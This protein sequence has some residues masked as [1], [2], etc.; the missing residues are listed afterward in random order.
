MQRLCLFYK[1]YKDRTPLYLHNLIPKNFQISFL[2]R[3]KHGFF[4]RSFFPSTI[5][6]LNNLE[7][8][9]R[10]AP[11]F[12]GFKQNIL[13]F[14]RLGPEKVYNV[15]NPSGLKL[16]TRLRLGLSYLH[17]HNSV[18]ILVIVSMNYAFAVL[19]SNLRTI[20]SS[21]AHYIY[22]KEK[23]LWRKCVILRFQFLIK[24]K[25]AFIIL[26]SLVALN[27][28]TLRI[29]TGKKHRQIKLLRLQNVR[30]W[31]FGSLVHQINSL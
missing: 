1:I 20:S 5:I 12:S 26:Y 10:N 21:N 23:P 25:T 29:L 9:L 16:L 30:I 3:V 28:M 18:I 6:E 13:K 8:Y 4:K 19:I 24:V 7:Y 15:H 14:V 31:A 27:L 11:S 2:F 17:A 22:L